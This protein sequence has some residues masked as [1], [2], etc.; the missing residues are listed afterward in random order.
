[1]VGRLPPAC[2]L[3]LLLRYA[4]AAVVASALIDTLAS[5]LD[6]NGAAGPETIAKVLNQVRELAKGIRGK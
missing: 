2:C 3:S 6:Q 5:T 4:D 1:M